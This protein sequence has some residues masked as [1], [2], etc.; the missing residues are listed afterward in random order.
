VR[1]VH[2]FKDAFP[3][4]YGGVEQ[5]VWDVTRSLGDGFESEVLTSSRSWRRVDERVDGV[6]FLRVPEYGRMV[7]TPVTPS[8]WGEIRR[9][10]PA[11]F[12]FHLPVPL[13]ELV[14]LA[15]W[16]ATP[17]VASW[18]ADVARN[19]RLARGYATVQRRFL[20]RVDRIVVSSQ[21]LADRAPGLAAHRDR[22]VV[23]PFGVDPAEWPADRR[24]VQELRRAARGPLVLFLGRLVR[25]KGVEV[26]VEAMRDVDATLLVVG[27]GPE[28]RA[29]ERA[30][31]GSRVRFVGSVTNEERSAYYRAADVFVLPAVSRAE[32]FGIA[33][34]EA[35]S[36]GTPAISTE[37]GTGTSWVNVAG[38]T[39]LVVPPADATALRAAITTVLGDHRM[40]AAMGEAA[41]DRAR[42]RFSKPEMLDRLAEVYRSAALRGEPEDVDVDGHGGAG[43]GLHGE[44]DGLRHAGR[45]EPGPDGVVGEQPPQ[46]RGQLAG[47]AHVDLEHPVAEVGGGPGAR[48]AYHRHAARQRL[49]RR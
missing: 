10:R 1:V 6:R 13:A 38:D 33:M 41:A 49:Q 25:Y 23:V 32:T 28:R 39:G 8:W 19:P 35:M 48:P 42:R 16:P 21:V 22:V 44:G 46:R 47:A 2:V 29:L 4:T 45:A 20:S 14:A 24:R 27:D 40:R 11:A 7:S 3:P 43:H 26:L 15:R 12:H 9:S 5:H 17:V 34:L 36:F 30:A 37:L 18:Y 31:A